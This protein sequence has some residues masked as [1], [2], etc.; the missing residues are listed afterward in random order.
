MT[1]AIELVRRGILVP[2]ELRLGPRERRRRSVYATAEVKTELIRIWREDPPSLCEADLSPKEQFNVLLRKFITGAPLVFDREFHALW[3]G[4]D[5][6]WE[7]KTPDLRLIGYFTSFDVFVA[8]SID[9]KDIIVKHGLMPGYCGVVVRFREQ[10]G[11]V[12][13][14]S[15]GECDVISV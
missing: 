5:A 1:T 2:L 4:E 11:T 8:V 7:L 14:N 6:V 9:F 10:Y 3:P 13:V 15:S 12:Y